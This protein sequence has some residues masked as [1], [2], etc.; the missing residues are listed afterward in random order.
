MGVSNLQVTVRERTGAHSFHVTM[1]AWSPVELCGF[2]F[3]YR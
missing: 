3:L 1:G 2:R